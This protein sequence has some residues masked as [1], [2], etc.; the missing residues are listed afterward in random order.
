MAV[1]HIVH[2]P[3]GV[4]LTQ[5]GAAATTTQECTIEL[6]PSQNTCT[7]FYVSRSV[8][9]VQVHAIELKYPAVW[10]NAYKLYR[11]SNS[12]ELSRSLKR[13]AVDREPLESITIV[14]TKEKLDDACSGETRYF[15]TPRRPD[16]YELL[17][18]LHRWVGLER[19]A[20]RR[21]GNTRC[22]S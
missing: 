8:L 11:A 15:H 4:I 7:S 19:F 13:G 22:L 18:C 17:T 21:W 5:L 2:P 1:D 6:I 14:E 12:F 16:L 10:G 20:A 3:N 9:I